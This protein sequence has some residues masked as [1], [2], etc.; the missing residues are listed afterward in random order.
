[1]PS[2]QIN[3]LSQKKETEKIELVARPGQGQVK[4]CVGDKHRRLE[5]RLRPQRSLHHPQLC[6]PPHLPSILPRTLR[7]QKHEQWLLV[8]S[9]VTTC[10]T[11]FSNSKSPGKSAASKRKIIIKE[12]QS[13]GVYSRQLKSYILSAEVFRGSI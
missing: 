1:M 10:T 11:P 2:R 4:K 3:D 13:T 12:R 9:G 7:F 8:Y 6:R 5:P